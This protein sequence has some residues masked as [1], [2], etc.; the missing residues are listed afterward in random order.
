MPSL[1]RP[2]LA[3]ISPPEVTA[4]FLL[5]FRADF[6]DLDT[7]VIT[8]IDI[9]RWVDMETRRFGCTSD[10]METLQEVLHFLRSDLLCL[11]EKYAA[12]RDFVCNSTALTSIPVTS[13]GWSVLTDAGKVSQDG[14]IR[15]DEIPQLEF[16]AILSAK[17]G[18]ELVMLEVVE[19]TLV[20]DWTCELSLSL[21]PD[22]QSEGRVSLGEIAQSG[23]GRCGGHVGRRVLKVLLDYRESKSTNY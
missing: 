9:D 4:S 23:D 3:S 16:G 1:G 20:L 10:C 6:L 5:S 7:L 2:E 15:V 19:R 11:Q 14:I 17:I 18:G 13:E 22:L 21:V 12:R 8:S